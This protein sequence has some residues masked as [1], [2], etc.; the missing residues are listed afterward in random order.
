MV[1][2]SAAANRH[3]ADRMRLAHA[4]VQESQDFEDTQA[5]NG[6]GLEYRNNL[7]ELSR[8]LSLQL[9]QGRYKVDLHRL[10]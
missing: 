5:N 6:L 7:F 10:C 4:C 3:N 9:P 2:A 1:T 8:V